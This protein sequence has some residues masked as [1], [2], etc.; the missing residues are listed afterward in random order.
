MD[1]GALMGYFIVGSCYGDYV[2][3]KEYRTINTESELH[4]MS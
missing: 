2:V 1:L 3:V 4:R